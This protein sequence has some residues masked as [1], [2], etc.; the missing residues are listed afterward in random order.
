MI[1]F[2]KKIGGDELEYVLGLDI[3]TSSLKGI[4]FN[5]NGN[6]VYSVKESYQTFHNG[7]GFS[8]Q[9]PDDWIKATDNVIKSLIKKQPDILEYLKGICFSGQMHSLVVL[10]DNNNV[11]RPA[12]LWNDVRTKKE[13]E[14]IVKRMGTRLNEVT[15]ND[16]MEGFT[17]P[18]V[19]WIKN[20]EPD[21]WKSIHTILLPKDY[22]RWWLTG[23]MKTDYSDA[24]GT[25]LFDIKEN[26]WSS[27]ICN[28]LNI[29][30]DILPEIVNSHD[31][32]GDLKSDISTR[33]GFKNKIQIFAGGSDN[34][35][36]AIGSGVIYNE[37][38]LVSIGTSGVFLVKLPNESVEY[39]KNIHLFN[40]GLENFYYAM[41]VTLS[42]GSSLN[43]LK[44]L[45]FS[46]ELTFYEVLND[47]KDVPLGSNGILFTP[48]L[49]GERT[50]YGD[51][52]IRASFIGLDSSHSIKD[53]AKSVMEGVTFSIKESQQIIEEASMMKTEYIV[54]VG[55]G[56]KNQEWIQIQADIFNRPIVT[57]KNE[58][59]PG[60][61]AGILAAYGLGWFDSLEEAC[62]KFV[63]YNEPIFPDKERAYKYERLYKLYKQVY[64]S[65]KDLT[66][67]LIDF[68]IDNKNK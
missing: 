52:K 43:W 18:K 30:I 19:L 27:E 1:I 62:S 53:I 4:L 22:V 32:V 65:T 38:S 21:I 16:L 47:L 60:I 50:P 46:N 55:G 10:D 48:Y 17:L 41:G 33:Y 34:A 11:L 51:S 63:K 49:S 61:G 59:G 24:S 57:L 14:L 2:I 68:V 5:R 45:F 20:N 35:C 3:G 12:I 29:D 40:L 23:N 9:D 13:C 8:E 36:A 26:K 67:N 15:K 56:S 7:V 66:H 44:N 64:S 25:F 39:N 58:E 37:Y 54:S 28:E 6:V 42:A 31:Y